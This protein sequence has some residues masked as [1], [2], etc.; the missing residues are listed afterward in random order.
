MNADNITGE[1][2]RGKCISKK[3]PHSCAIYSLGDSAETFAMIYSGMS[4]DAIN[5]R[6][7]F[8]A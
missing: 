2:A 4:Q 8:C 5:R 1:Y 7:V 6:Y 3:S